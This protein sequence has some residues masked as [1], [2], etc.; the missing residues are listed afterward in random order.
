M[1][2]LNRKIAPLRDSEQKLNKKL[3][4]EMKGFEAELAQF[5]GWVEDRYYWANV[6]SQL[7]Q[8]LMDVESRTTEAIEKLR[9]G[10]AAPR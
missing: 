8:I 2:E 7:R 1:E 6:L 3:L 5:N 10:S 9:G 4:P